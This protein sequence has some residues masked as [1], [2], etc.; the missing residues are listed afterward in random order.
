MLPFSKSFSAAV[1]LGFSMA[2]ER[3]GTEEVNGDQMIVYSSWELD[4]IF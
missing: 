1:E 2:S 4:F 3:D